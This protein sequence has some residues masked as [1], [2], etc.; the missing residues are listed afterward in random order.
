MSRLDR[1]Y[2]RGGTEGGRNQE[3]SGGGACNPSPPALAA[4]TA[5][6]KT[7]GQQEVGTRLHEHRGQDR[8]TYNTAP[9]IGALQSLALLSLLPPLQRQSLL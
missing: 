8:E 4:E 5:A 3:K 7:G 1:I 9:S 6:P 2:R